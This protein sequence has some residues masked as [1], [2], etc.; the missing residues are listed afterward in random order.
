M[1]YV[2]SAQNNESV[3]FSC[4]PNCF[5]FQFMSEGGRKE[6]YENRLFLT[7]LALWVIFATFLSI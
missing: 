3:T 2:R 5:V 1:T 4:V 7:K 6:C